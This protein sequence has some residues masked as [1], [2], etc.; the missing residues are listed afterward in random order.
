[1]KE[2]CKTYLYATFNL[3]L[4]I[5]ETSNGLISKKNMWLG[6]PD[7]PEPLSLHLPTLKIFSFFVMKNFLHK[8]FVIK[9]Q[10]TTYNHVQNIVGLSLIIKKNPPSP[11]IQCWI[12]KEKVSGGSIVIAS[13]LNGGREG[14]FVWYSAWFRIFC[15]L[16]YSYY[17][18]Y[19]IW[20]F[21]IL[22][23]CHQLTQRYNILGGL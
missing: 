17:I 7:R 18:D 13:I 2:L 21:K 14:H 8:F 19:T 11:H 22:Q 23:H 16:L 1:M 5:F 4:K 6:W 3:K 12:L 20:P 9:F 10:Y 15:T